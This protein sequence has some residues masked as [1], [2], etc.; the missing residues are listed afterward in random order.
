MSFTEECL[1]LLSHVCSDSNQISFT[2]VAAGKDDSPRLN[3]DTCQTNLEER[4]RMRSLNYLVVNR[5]RVLSGGNE[6]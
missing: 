1:L 4:E 2:S 5:I 6:D 3:P